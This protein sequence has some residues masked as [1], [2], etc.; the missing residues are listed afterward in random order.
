[1]I[2]TTDPSARLSLVYRG[3][4]WNVQRAV[5]RGARLASGRGG[6]LWYT[7]D[8]TATLEYLETFRGDPRPRNGA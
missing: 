6:K 1:L 7:S 8:E 5:A 3:R 2:V 4:D